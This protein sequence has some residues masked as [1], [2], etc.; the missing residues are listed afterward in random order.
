MK[1]FYRLHSRNN[2]NE[3]E[4]R[5]TTKYL[6]NLK[7]E[8]QDEIVDVIWDIGIMVTTAKKLEEWKQHV[9]SRVQL[10]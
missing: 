5:T 1:E 8:L 2:M 4:F 10:R 6:G 7:Q 9:I 3:S